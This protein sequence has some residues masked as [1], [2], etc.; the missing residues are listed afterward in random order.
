MSGTELLGLQHPGDIVGSERGGHLFAAMAV[1]H[2]QPCRVER[3]RGFQHVAEQRTSRERLQ[4]LGQ[5]R[6]HARAL[7]GG[8]DDDPYSH[9]GPSSGR[10]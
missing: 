7:A 10:S 5:V 3:T 1:D 4:H 8:K 9:A 6:A 2:V